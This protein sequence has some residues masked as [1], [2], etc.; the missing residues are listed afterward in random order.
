MFCKK[1]LQGTKCGIMFQ[2]FLQSKSMTFSM[3]RRL[4]CVSLFILLAVLR[5][6][7]HAEP[8]SFYKKKLFVV[9]YDNLNVPKTSSQT[10]VMN[11]LLTFWRHLEGYSIVI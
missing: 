6:Q 10:D 2:F 3:L 8:R 11:L 5:I 7:V 1:F 9:D 4:Y